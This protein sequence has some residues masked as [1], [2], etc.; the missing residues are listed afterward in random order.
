MPVRAAPIPLSSLKVAAPRVEELSSIEASLRLDAIA[1]A[2]FRL[3]R[4]KMA[5][6]V[7][8]GDVRVNWRAAPKPSA[9]VAAGD[10]ISV[11][12][13]GRLEIKEVGTTAK[14]KFSVKMVRYV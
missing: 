12:G 9:D 10:V 14:G 13:K 7:K 1:S 5:D 8:G 4:S 2:G 11:A 6:L 3:S